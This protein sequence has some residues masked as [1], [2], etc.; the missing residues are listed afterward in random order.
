MAWLLWPEP[1]PPKPLPPEVAIAGQPLDLSRDPVADAFDLVRR[2]ARQTLVLKLPDG[3]TRESC[4]AARRRDLSACVC[5]RW[6]RTRSTRT[7]PW[8]VRTASGD[9]S[10]PTRASSCL[11]RCRFHPERALEVLVSI[12][13][14]VYR[15]AT[16]AAIDSWD[17]R[18]LKP[19]QVGFRL[20]AYGT[21]ARLD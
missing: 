18:E 9:E 17:K 2:Y 14:G 13:E 12:K 8:C 19:E 1:P 21:L 16:D 10:I 5:R 4:R 15:A 7:A 3:K 20:D 11:F 6:S